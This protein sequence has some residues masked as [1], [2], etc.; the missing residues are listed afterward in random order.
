MK[1]IAFFALILVLVPALTFAG[2]P[3][4]EMKAEAAPAWYKVGTVMTYGV[5]AFGK[6]Y[7]FVVTIKKLD[8]EIEFDWRMT[9]PVN[10]SGSVK[11]CPEG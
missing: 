6:Q 7:D 8:K 11:R 9:E 3:P 5:D 10:N 4:P 2:S 1:H